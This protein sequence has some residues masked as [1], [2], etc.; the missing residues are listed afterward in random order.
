MC[1][2]HNNWHDCKLMN[3]SFVYCVDEREKDFNDLVIT[4]RCLNDGNY[5]EYIFTAS[6]FYRTHDERVNVY[7]V[8]E[9]NLR[10]QWQC[11]KLSSSLKIKSKFAVRKK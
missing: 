4:V 11:I 5:V 8:D 10:F 7:A 6:Q 3:C 1:S 2:K 9:F